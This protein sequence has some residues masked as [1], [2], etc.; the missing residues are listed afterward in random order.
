M[1]IEIHNYEENKQEALYFKLS[2]AF[3]MDNEDGKAKKIQG[4]YAIYNENVCM[5][6]GQSKN[7]AS[8]VATHI[9]GKYE[10]ATQ[11]YCWNVEKIGFGDFTKRSTAIQK[12]ILDNCEQY[13]MA[14]LKPIDNILIDMD[15]EIAEDSKPNIDFN[16]FANITVSKYNNSCLVIT[17]SYSILSDEIISNISY[18]GYLKKILEKTEE[19]IYEAL[20][21]CDVKT[22]RELGV[23]NEA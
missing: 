16:D 1:Y 11:I 3:S 7:L 15:K 19:I 4:I 20:E 22:F 6:V 21:K 18:F 14:K 12:Q 8:R 17:D 10:N 9:R 23:E 5:Y 13:L 2:N